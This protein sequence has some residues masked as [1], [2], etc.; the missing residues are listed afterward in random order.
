MLSPL[1]CAWVWAQHMLCGIPH[2]QNLIHYLGGRTTEAEAEK[3]VTSKSSA[4]PLVRAGPFL[5]S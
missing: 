5:S 4:P 3:C 2:D 1:G